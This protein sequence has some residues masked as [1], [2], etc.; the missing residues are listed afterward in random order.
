MQRRVDLEG[1]EVRL[2]L[3]RGAVFLLLR[4]G[5]IVSARVAGPAA[6]ESGRERDHLVDVLEVEDVLDLPQKPLLVLGRLDGGESARIG[7][8]EIDFEESLNLRERE[9]REGRG[10]S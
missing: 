6:L 1:H 4:V 8:I 9:R 3:V 10:V 5:R 7:A 2:P